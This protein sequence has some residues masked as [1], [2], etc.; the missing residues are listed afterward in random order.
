M[1]LK[2][3]EELNQYEE[4]TSDGEL[5]YSFSNQLALMY[6]VAEM[7]KYMFGRAL[8]LKDPQVPKE[9]SDECRDQTFSID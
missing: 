2:Y 3:N 4:H 8:G 5:L 9:R 1:S 6:G 7:D